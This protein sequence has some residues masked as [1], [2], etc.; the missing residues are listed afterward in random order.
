[1]SDYQIHKI[2]CESLPCGTRGWAMTRTACLGFG[3]CLHRVPC[4]YTTMRWEGSL[5]PL[6]A[7]RTHTELHFHSQL[8]WLQKLL[9]SSTLAISQTWLYPQSNN[10]RI[11]QP[12]A[13]AV[14]RHCSNDHRQRE[15]LALLA[16]NTRKACWSLGKCSCSSVICS[17]IHIV[18]K[19]W[20]HISKETS[21][22]WQLVECS[23]CVF[24]LM[25]I[26]TSFLAM[27]LKPHQFIISVWNVWTL[28]ETRVQVHHLHAYKISLMVLYFTPQTLKRGCGSK[29]GVISTCH[30]N[31]DIRPI[32]YKQ[33]DK[34][35]C[36]FWAL[37]C[38]CL[39][40][41]LC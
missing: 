37:V 19:S 9:W 1:M 7:D 26:K 2:L 36:L 10:A 33:W 41:S 31:S 40:K 13:C 8:K 28:K 18:T 5:P 39:V 38:M 14:Q 32:Y 15:Q 35:S 30:G 4:G 24:F 25:T 21:L 22:A 23:K 20:C 3:V 12:V 29:L 17:D 27:V 34:K 11:Q 6:R 16:A